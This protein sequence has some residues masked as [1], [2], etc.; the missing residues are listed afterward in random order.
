M[1]TL[2]PT[3]NTGLIGG[4]IGYWPAYGNSWAGSIQQIVV[5]SGVSS[6][7]DLAKYAGWASWYTGQAGANLPA[8]SPYKTA[9]PYASYAADIT[10]LGSD[11]NYLLGA[12]GAPLLRAA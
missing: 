3:T 7:G 10:L 11:G 2:G 8:G 9:P 6:A 12:D 5:V 4:G 1:A